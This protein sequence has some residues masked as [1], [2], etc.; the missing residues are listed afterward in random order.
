MLRR[1]TYP[2]SIYMLFGRVTN[3]EMKGALKDG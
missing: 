2:D 3:I 1:I